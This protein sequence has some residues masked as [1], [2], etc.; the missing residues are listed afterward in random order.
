MTGFA[1][2]LAAGAEGFECD[3]RLSA[4]G[5][6]VVIHDPTLDRTT[7][8]TG[9]VRG[10]TAA[11]LARVDAACRFVAPAGITASGRAGVPLF[12]DVLAAFPGA[13]VIVELKDADLALADAVVDVLRRTSATA[14]VCAGSFHHDVLVRV[15]RIAPELAT[16]GSLPEARGVL[17]RAQVRWPF[18]RGAAFDALQVPPARGRLRVVTPRFVRQAHQEGALVQVWTVNTP[19]EVTRL[20]KMGVDGIISDR[21]DVAVAARDAVVAGQ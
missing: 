14:R 21:P 3:V 11:E 12:A 15:R 10:R 18:T 5:R 17:V 16:G 6:P 19:V 1:A 13:R 2:G 20:L 7:D 8:V 9:P 4:D